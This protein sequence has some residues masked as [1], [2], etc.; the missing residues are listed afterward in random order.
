MRQGMR[1]RYDFFKVK[2]YITEFVNEYSVFDERYPSNFTYFG[3]RW[4]SIE[5]AYNNMK[6]D[7][8]NESQKLN[9]MG[10]ILYAFYKQNDV[11]AAMLISTKDMWLEKKVKNHDNFWHNC[12]CAECF[13]DMGEN[14]YGR[15]LMEIRDRLIWERK[16]YFKGKK[17]WVKKYF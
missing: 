2:G 3:E 5:Q 1:A 14:N 12:T 17:N 15:L 4:E 7:S 13:L 16:P 6:E 10:N 9:L 8:F 11:A